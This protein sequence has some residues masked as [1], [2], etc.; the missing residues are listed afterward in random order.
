MTIEDERRELVLGTV[1]RSLGNVKSDKARRA[2]VRGRLENHP[3]GTIPARA[4]V[5]H[6]RQIDLFMEM[7]I[8][9]DTSVDRVKTKADILDAVTKFLRNHNLPQSLVHGDDAYLARLPWGKF[10]TLEH[11]R[12]PAAGNDH[13]SLAKAHSGVAETGTLMMASG[14]DNPVT[15]NFLPD[16]SIVVLEAKDIAGDYE[17]AWDKLRKNYGTREMPRTLNMVTGPSRTADI[18]QTLL[19]G[20]HG[21]RSL[22]IIIVGR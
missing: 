21:P 4:Q 1:R 13:V 12:G 14:A 7:A 9:V 2:I 20:A 15:L 11:R 19:L 5:N 3:R 22:H 16:V 8:A 18:E 10:K 17:T 6:F